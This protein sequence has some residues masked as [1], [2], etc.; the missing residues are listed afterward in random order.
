M[1][2]TVKISANSSWQLVE[3]GAK[4]LLLN[5]TSGVLKIAITSSSDSPA[6]DFSNTFMLNSNIVGGFVGPVTL[7]ANNY[8]YVKTVSGTNS[9]LEC[10]VA[11]LSS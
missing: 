3:N 6:E 7:E 1:T 2:K 10:I 4:S 5:P 8:L 9:E 11:D